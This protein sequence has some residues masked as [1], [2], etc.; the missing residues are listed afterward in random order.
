MNVPVGDRPPGI[1]ESS[2]CV[3]VPTYNEIDNLADMIDRLRR[4]VPAA[5]LVILDDASPDGT[6]ELA[7]TIAADDTCV[8]VLHRPHKEGLGPAYLEGLA[9]ARSHG[10]AAAVQID[11]DGSHQP[12]QLPALLTAAQ[13]ADVVIG[14]RWVPGGAVRN[15]PMHRKALSLGGNLFVRVALGIPIRDATAGFRVYQLAAL[16]QIRLQDVASHGYCFQV[17]LTL[18]AHDA[19]LRIVEVPIEFVERE[20]GNSKMGTSIVAEALIRVTVWGVRRRVRQAR[21]SLSLA[22]RRRSDRPAHTIERT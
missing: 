17:D 9:W 12:E 3:M 14:S 20:H 18:R 16:E 10:F 15:W 5:T 2:V 22:S 11:A 7:D 13:S 8:H 19:D 21:A 4:C 1:G 6:G